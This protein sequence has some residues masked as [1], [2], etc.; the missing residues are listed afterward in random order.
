MGRGEENRPTRYSCLVMWP[1]GKLLEERRVIRLELLPD[2]IRT[3]DSVL[4]EPQRDFLLG[5]FPGSPVVA[6]SVVKVEKYGVDHGVSQG[7]PKRRRPPQGA[8]SLATLQVRPAR[9]RG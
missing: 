1:R 7:S 6:Q 2:G 8:A 4:F 5:A 3:A 9:R